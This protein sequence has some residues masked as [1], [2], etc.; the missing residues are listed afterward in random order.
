LLEEYVDEGVVFYDHTVTVVEQSL[1]Y[2]NE[3]SSLGGE[4]KRLFFRHLGRNYGR[5]VLATLTVPR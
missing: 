1:S 2:L 3:V 4:E 5:T